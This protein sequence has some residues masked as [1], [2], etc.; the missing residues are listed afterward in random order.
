MNEDNR[1]EPL[2][3][4][5]D[6]LVIN[7]PDF[8][9]HGLILIVDGDPW[10][11]EKDGM[12]YYPIR[13]VEGNLGD[14]T[15]AQ[16][17]SGS[18]RLYS[19]TAVQLPERIREL[20]PDLMVMPDEEVTLEYRWSHRME[21]VSVKRNGHEMYNFMGVYHPDGVCEGKGICVY[22]GRTLEFD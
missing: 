18:L 5:G 4:K 20:V 9:D 21:T 3:K 16:I 11:H 13:D 19:V 10:W 1:A 12:W 2:A 7:D 17:A 22:C 8:P 15:D 14:V 6:R